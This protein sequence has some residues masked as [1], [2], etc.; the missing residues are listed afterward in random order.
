[1][2]Q[3]PAT[4][5]ITMVINKKLSVKAINKLNSIGIQSLY[6]EA[7]RT[8][9][10]K[11][12]KGLSLLMNRVNLE[13]GPV[14]LITFYIPKKDEKDI[15]NYLYHE[16]GYKTPGRGN[17]ISQDIKLMNGHDY[18]H[19][20]PDTDI[21]ESGKAILFSELTG[22]CCVLQRGDEDK[23]AKASL[24]KGTS[25]PI[26]TYGEGSGVRDK[27]GLLRITISPEKALINLVVSTYDTEAVLE[28][29]VTEGRLYE[30][31]RGITYTYEIKQG[32]MNTKISGG[33]SGEVASI[34]QVV[35][36][37]D[38]IKGGMEWRRSGRDNQSYRKRP[39]MTNLMELTLICDDGM[40][41]YL[42]T[43][44]M[45]HGAPGATIS[46]IKYVTMFEEDKTT[47]VR[48]M[49]RMIISPDLIQRVVAS[50]EDVG[51]FSDEGHGFIYS[52]P[53][54]KAFTYLSKKK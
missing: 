32:I 49:C 22:I 53:V 48:E 11:E 40:A 9:I 39:F 8:S 17:L 24:D 4:S 21:P 12:K 34:E 28:L 51:G 52:L 3:Y 35:Y 2:K 6:L 23:L 47:V 20:N 50:I 36:A 18:F 37:L 30:P 46:K 43:T 33:K 38:A 29:F 19:Q 45:E 14:E 54:P 10:L 1:M 27:L 15:M 13:Y 5:K 41:T 25:V 26:T 16:F 42:A 44:A 7:G 31:G